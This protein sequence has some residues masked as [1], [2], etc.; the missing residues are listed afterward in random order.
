MP[1]GPVNPNDSP[2]GQ[3][4]Y[5]YTHPRKPLCSVPLGHIAQGSGQLNGSKDRCEVNH[6]CILKHSMLFL[7]RIPIHLIENP[8]TLWVPTSRVYSGV[9]AVQH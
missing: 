8:G 1:F 4:V 3:Y 6:V 5:N 7:P 2:S 9:N